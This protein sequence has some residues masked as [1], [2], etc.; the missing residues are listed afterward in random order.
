MLRSFRVQSA[1]LTLGLLLL[2]RPLAARSDRPLAPGVA[3]EARL[4]L[5]QPH[6]YAIALCSGE[7]FR[8]RIEQN[9]LDV[10]ARILAPDGI[11][12]A[13]VDNATDRSDPLTVSIVAAGDG[14]HRIVVALR[15]RRATR[16]RYR[17]IAEAP[18][19]AVPTDRERIRAERLRAEADQIV[20][21][22]AA[23]SGEALER[24]ET[25]RDTFRWI[26]DRP[27]EAA[28][29]GRIADA[30]GRLGRL[31]ETLVRA[32]EMLELWQ[33]E[34]DRRGEAAALDRVGLAYSEIGDQR[35]ALAYLERALEMRR[36]DG[37]AWG[38]AE[39]LNDIA[40]AR[41]ALGEIPE[42]IARYTDSLEHA[43]RSGD[44]LI[45]AW[46][47][48]NRAVDFRNLGDV[49]RGLADSRRAREMF[50]ALGDKHQEGVV[51][52]GIGSAYLELDDVPQALRHYERARDL[53]KATGDKRFEA[54]TLNH[55][56]LARL[57]SGKPEPALRDF[58][59]AWQLLRECGDQRGV[60]MASANIGNARLALGDVAGGRERLREALVEVRAS[61]DRM[62]ESVALVYL[63]RAEKAAGDLPASRDRLEEALELTEALRGSIPEAGERAA[64]M[65]TTRDRYDLL[66]DVLM[67]LHAREPDRGWDAAALH[68][69]ERARARSL[70]ELMA[71]ARIDLR[72]GIDES[73]LEKERALEAELERRR[74]E[75][76]LRLAG[77]ADAPPAG[78]PTVDALLSDYRDVQ[79]RIR[80]E[81][82]RYAALV[83]P[84]P[85]SLA[86]VQEQVLD[87]D[88]LLL[89]YAL[90]E[91]RSFLFAVTPTTFTSYV[92]PRRAVIETAA[93]R[94]YEAWST[95]GKLEAA[96][97][98]RR[99][100]AV[101][102]MLLGPV[103]AQLGRKRLAIVAEGAIQYVPFAA[104]PSPGG[105]PAARL[106]EAHEV[107]SLPSATTLAV[108][109]R[110]ADRRNRPE[111]TVAVLADP[112]FDASDPRVTGQEGSA[113]AFRPDAFGSDDL[114][115]SMQEAG[116]ARLDRLPS[117]RREAESI[118]A[119]ASTG[120]SFTALDFRA[121]RATALSSEVSRARIVHFASHGL[122]NSR[123]PELS[124]IV[125]SLVDERG[126]PVDGFFQTRDIYKLRLSAELV[127]LSACQTALGKE[128]RGEGL[129][130][131][132]RGFMYAG[133]PRIVASLWRV[134]DRATAVFMAEF[135]RGVLRQGLT[136]AAALRAAQKRF[137]GDKL[138]S[139]PYYWAAFTLQG[140]WE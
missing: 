110:E 54:F 8:V 62:H 55:M 68:A 30:L 18:R 94:L 31:R 78:R 52:Y 29:L 122:L 12:F 1:V 81:S 53:L 93:R 27:E 19:T 23:K 74:R 133:T 60:A 136:P 77:T 10:V 84:E 112:V 33:L 6:A 49:D 75:E 91:K 46:V 51:E 13:E 36:A 42:A 85:L 21:R 35:Q 24:Y 50:R 16:G 47:W 71:E 126:R 43:R 4:A 135:Y 113:G 115:R 118:A 105:S 89:E 131:L 97:I 44:R 123:H 119:L 69:S 132:S 120:A 117:S 64:F 108:L 103:A 114:T 58:Q 96:E 26:G 82:P 37:D 127:V 73:L 70:V 65:A 106:A 107:V 86:Q 95:S 111:H 32:E 101:S 104:L 76:P 11:A 128:V 59:L 134:P 130:G 116:L 137:Q 92:L 90:G 17:V 34:A 22:D 99:E 98:G 63:A 80:A 61:G 2:S 20:S 124:G 67:D 87:A 41:G 7:F 39:T 79:R 25:A 38:Q 72:E 88:T 121:S 45:Q 138:W 66:I 56:G 129:I 9:H 83:R 139:N 40:V 109:R 5:N 15:G 28:T 140:E 48:N 125:L 3:V 14:M 57:S 102:R 100:H